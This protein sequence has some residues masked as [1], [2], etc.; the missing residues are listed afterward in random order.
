MLFV[1]S[2]KYKTLSVKI[3]WY[4]DLDNAYDLENF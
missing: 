1:M 4:A 2:G 3:N